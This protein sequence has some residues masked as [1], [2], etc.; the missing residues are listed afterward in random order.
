MTFESTSRARVV[1]ELNQ[2]VKLHSTV[3]HKVMLI[4]TLH[5]HCAEVELLTD[6]LSLT[7]PQKLLYIIE[8]NRISFDQCGG[9]INPL[10]RSIVGFPAW[11]DTQTGCIGNI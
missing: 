9:V 6:Q 3:E 10:I 2:L 11:D 8:A 5:Y 1:I 4:Q 7:A